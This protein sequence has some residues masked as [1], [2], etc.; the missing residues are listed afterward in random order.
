MKKFFYVA[1]AAMFAFSSCASD[2]EINKI[3]NDESTTID[4]QVT[5]TLAGG[6]RAGITLPGTNTTLRYIIQVFDA[7]GAPYTGKAFD[8]GDELTAQ[9]TGIRVPKNQNYTVV[10]W[11]DIVDATAE[12]DVFYDTSSDLDDIQ[13]KSSFSDIMT[14]QDASNGLT[15]LDA[16]SGTADQDDVTDG[17]ISIQAMKRPLAKFTLTVNAD[18]AAAVIGTSDAP[19]KATVTFPVYYQ[20]F[21][22][23]AQAVE[24]DF[25]EKTFTVTGVDFEE[26]DGNKIYWGYLLCDDTNS[27]A[28]LEEVVVE[29][30]KG[31]TSIVE[32]ELGAIPFQRNWVTNVT[33]TFF[34]STVTVNTTISPD[35][36]GTSDVDEEGEDLD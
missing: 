36:D 13:I 15:V 12:A 20:T 35:W 32:K 6:T 27:G 7:A 18:D 19:D 8:Y 33:G 2:Q 1:L 28:T 4:V 14:E 22:A 23:L 29:F 9:F 17:V 11:A 21:N 24:N 3:D 30:L 10:A 34:S 25:G 26:T 16:F 5:P 31:T